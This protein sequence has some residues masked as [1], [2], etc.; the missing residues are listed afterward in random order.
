[1]K[2]IVFGIG[3]LREEKYNDHWCWRKFL[4]ELK[5]KDSS[6]EFE[7]FPE[8]PEPFPQ[9]LMRAMAESAVL[10]TTGYQGRLVYKGGKLYWAITTIGYDKI[11]LHKYGLGNE[12]GISVPNVDGENWLEVEKIL[13]L[14]SEGKKRAF[15]DHNSN[16]IHCLEDQTESFQYCCAKYGEPQPIC[17]FGYRLGR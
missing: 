9:F 3:L 12:L 14:L 17:N 7:I 4:E 13:R 1:M 15:Y 6:V 8:F 11:A 10:V 5:K 2:I 16:E